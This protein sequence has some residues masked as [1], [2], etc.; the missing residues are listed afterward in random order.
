LNK[1][2]RIF[3]VFFDKKGERLKHMK[4]IEM[5]FEEIQILIKRESK[6]D[7]FITLKELFELF[8]EEKMN[9][10]EDIDEKLPYYRGIYY[11][12]TLSG[13]VLFPLDEDYDVLFNSVQKMSAEFAKELLKAIDAYEK[14]QKE[15]ESALEK[16]R[17]LVK[18]QRLRTLF[19]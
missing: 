12:D 9:Y 17:T 16:M 3:F 8:G 13:I 14:M 6:F 1:R 2:Q 19:T 15:T 10:I 18:T 5:T 4:K 7:I 11:M